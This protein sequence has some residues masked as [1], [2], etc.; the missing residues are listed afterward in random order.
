ML[1]LQEV[2]TQEGSRGSDI[3]E[4]EEGGDGSENM[5]GLPVLQG[6]SQILPTPAR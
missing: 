3:E 1:N 2:D 6:P 5:E 4:E